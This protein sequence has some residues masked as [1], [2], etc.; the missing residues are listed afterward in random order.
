MNPQAILEAAR[1][2]IAAGES[3]DDVARW[4]K[5]ATGMTIDD[6]AARGAAG[7]RVAASGN[8]L[9]D[10][11]HQAAEGL[12]GQGDKLA[13][14][15]AAVIPGGKNYSEAREA[16]QQRTDDLKLLAPEAS[17]AASKVPL[18]AGGALAG[19]RGLGAATRAI[20]QA[21]IG[22]PRATGL[23]DA[24][25]RPVM[26]PTTRSAMETL[27]ALGQNP[28][29]RTAGRAAK[30]LGWG[31]GGLYALNQLREIFGGNNR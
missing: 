3:P 29:L 27:R 16:F 18:M 25:G 22:A 4:I 31:G 8:A 7:L 6:L 2:A 5:D 13:G 30:G 11:A 19:L 28:A 24:L 15:A 23:L 14:A 10:F 17:G 26:A 20:Q 21:R 9:T 12:F 1:A